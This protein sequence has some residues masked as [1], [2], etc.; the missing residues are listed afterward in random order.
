MNFPLLF[1]LGNYG[2]SY[3]K[4]VSKES[5]RLSNLSQSSHSLP[6]RSQPQGNRSSAGMTTHHS[7]VVWIL[8]W[9]PPLRRLQ[10]NHGSPIQYRIYGRKTMIE[11][12]YSYCWG[13]F[14]LDSSSTVPDMVT[15]PMR[16]SFRDSFNYSRY[17]SMS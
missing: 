12:V 7:L 10:K 2:A 11:K 1:I 16:R 8:Y 5:F 3:G 9:R 17:L 6:I 4:N 14:N 13:T 15:Y